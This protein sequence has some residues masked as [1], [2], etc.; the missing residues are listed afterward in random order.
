MQV[1]SYKI[2][3]PEMIDTPAMVTYPHLV[4]SNIDE[5][6]RMCGGAEN[7][8]PH[9]KTHKSKSVIEMQVE[10]GI[11]SYKCATLK[12]AEMAVSGG[13]HEIILAYPL[14]HPIK[15]RRFID[16]VQKYPDVTFRTIASTEEHLL[17]MS[18]MATK[19][20]VTLDV[21]MDLDTGMRRTGVQPGMK[22]CDFYCSIADKN[23]LN[24]VGVHVFDG[25][26]LYITDFERR[27]E[28]AT[29]TVSS[30][31][32]IWENAE[33][34]Q[35]PVADNLVGGSWSFSHYIQE[36]NIRVTPGTWIY[37][38]TRN[39]EMEELDFDIASLILGQVID[40]DDDKDTVTVDIGSKSSSSDQP[41]VHRFKIM[42]F[43]N[44]ELIAQSEEH[45]VVK[46][47]GDI[48]N[49]GDYILAAPG[50]ACTLTVKFPFTNVISEKGL[51][52][53]FFMHDARD[54]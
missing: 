6:I 50:H 41:L 42:G 45:G 30:L 32:D 28:L 48:L 25:E 52:E 4:A 19:D 1:G 23:N 16:M 53:G 29:R 44:T 9:A 24:P 31:K 47:N 54:R 2:A 13:A 14:L 40:S 33:K 17:A 21:Y 15:L 46:L 51:P 35:I 18:K 22:A 26:T 27:S 5:I 43:P 38:D 11:F 12:E 49:V 34:N 20:N 37:W 10:K 39:A 3:S 7:I 36:P 8:V